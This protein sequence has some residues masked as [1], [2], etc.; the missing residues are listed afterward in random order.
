MKKIIT[1]SLFSLAIIIAGVSVLVP[2]NVHAC[3]FCTQDTPTEAQQVADN[4]AKLDTA[5]PLPKLDNSLERTNISKRLSLY[6]DP[7]KISY[8]YLT[9]YGRVM[10]FYAVKGKVTSGNKRLTSPQKQVG[11]DWCSQGNCDLIIE[12]PELDGTYGS[13][14]PYIYFWTTEG[15]YVQWNGEYMLSDQP[16][17]L[18]TTPELVREIK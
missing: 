16:L 2:K 12:A 6:N 10:A 1:I 11:A 13:S 14:N 3:W 18:T 15:A 8:I 4:Q 7:A 9:S 5:V 17:K